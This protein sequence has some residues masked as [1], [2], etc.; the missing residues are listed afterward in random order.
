MVENMEREYIFDK[1]IILDLSIKNIDGG[2]VLIA[3]LEHGVSIQLMHPNINDM[4]NKIEE[5]L[6]IT[7]KKVETAKNSEENDAVND[8]R[9][10]SCF[11]MGQQIETIEELLM[12]KAKGLFY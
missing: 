8:L 3:T 6:E 4:R 7:P 10:N 12:E 5:I 11:E 9:P 1:K 2:D